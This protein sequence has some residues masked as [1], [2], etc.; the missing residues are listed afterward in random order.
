MLR[1]GDV[2]K[3]VRGTAM[4][5]QILTFDF[6]AKETRI[7]E[8]QICASATFESRWMLRREPS[9]LSAIYF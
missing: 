3:Q 8:S 6:T 5:T 1:S 9:G 4:S 2:K 7:F